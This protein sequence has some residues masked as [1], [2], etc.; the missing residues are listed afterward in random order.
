MKN[1]FKITTLSLMM[2]GIFGLPFFAGAQCQVL[3]NSLKGKL[4]LG[5]QQKGKIWYVAPSDAKK[6]E[7]TFANALPLFQK[8]AIGITDA[9]LNKIPLHTENRTSTLGNAS[10]GKLFLQVEQRGKIWYI[11]FSGK[12]WE[13][14]WGNLM[15]LFQKLAL[16]ITDE[17]LNKITCGSF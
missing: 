17:D 16:G 1:W 12:R 7:V 6:Y 2:V 5:V 11:D 8:F 9:N 10:K 14:T 15:E 13:V 3:A 4:L